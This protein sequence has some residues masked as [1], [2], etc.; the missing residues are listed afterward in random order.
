MTKE[1][2]IQIYRKIWA[3]LRHDLWM[4]IQ[5]AKKE[6]HKL[7]ISGEAFD[8]LWE[9]VFMRFDAVRTDVYNLIMDDS[10]NVKESKFIMLK[11]YIEF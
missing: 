11:A 8:E 1:L 2:Y 3:S 9:E 5:S 7:E 4:E 6:E 10:K